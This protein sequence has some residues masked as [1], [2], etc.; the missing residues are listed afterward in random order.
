MAVFE[1]KPRTPVLLPATDR[2]DPGP[3]DRLQASLKTEF[4]RQGL[5]IGQFHPRCEAPGLWS[6]DF[7]PLRSPIPL[8]AMR[9]MVA[10]D[11]P[12]LVGDPDHLLAYF[13]RFGPDL[14]T[15]TRRFLVERLIDR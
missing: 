1:R 9:E 8:L 7:R 4:V 2:L 3:L 11:L 6:P 14:P 10:S 15:Q 12:F 13:D 5:M